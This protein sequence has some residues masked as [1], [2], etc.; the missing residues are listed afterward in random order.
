VPCFVALLFLLAGALAARST[1][2]VMMGHHAPSDPVG[3]NGFWPTAAGV[4]IAA[5]MPEEIS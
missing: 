3:G 5:A 1:P 4:K 2:V